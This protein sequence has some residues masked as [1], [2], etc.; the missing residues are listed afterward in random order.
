[1]KKIIFIS[2]I[3]VLIS[4]CNQNYF[5][6]DYVEIP[7]ETWGVDDIVKFTFEISDADVPY[8]L[9]IGIKHGEHF[10]YRNLWLFVRT[11]APNGN[12]QFDTINCILADDK[13][14]WI[15]KCKLD[16]CNYLVPFG[17]SVAFVETG[18]YTVEIQQA[19]R[20]DEVPQ[21][22]EIGFIID[23]LE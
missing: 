23:K 19:L 17:D 11:T 6:N 22:H 14:K 8:N 7:E 4:S 1:M 18:I 12:S 9:L 21:I 3:I 2:F 10:P 13:Y 5:Y 15:G 16:I 20:Q